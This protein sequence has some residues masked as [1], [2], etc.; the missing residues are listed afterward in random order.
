MYGEVPPPP[1]GA[2]VAALSIASLAIQSMRLLLSDIGKPIGSP[3]I[4]VNDCRSALIVAEN[5]GSLRTRMTH[6]PTSAF[7]VR[8]LTRDHLIRLLWAPTDHLAADI[9]T[10]NLGKV[11]FK[12]FQDFVLG[13]PAEEQ[14]RALLARVIRSWG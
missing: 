13:L 4:L 11:K 12:R 10:K 7:K 2:T 5:P 8:E 9:L 1:F 3:T 6:L 14:V